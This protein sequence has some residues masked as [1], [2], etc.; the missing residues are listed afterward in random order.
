VRLPLARGDGDGGNDEIDHIDDGT[1]A[2]RFTGI[3][4][5]ENVSQD[6]PPSLV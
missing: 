4:G 3:H 5:T 2:H 1:S 6:S